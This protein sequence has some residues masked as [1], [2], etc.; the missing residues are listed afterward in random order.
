MSEHKESTVARRAEMANILR[1]WAQ[2]QHPPTDLSK[3]V[4]AMPDLPDGFGEE[5]AEC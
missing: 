3:V 2:R 1:L 4:G 5:E